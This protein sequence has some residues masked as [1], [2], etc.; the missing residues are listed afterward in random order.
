MDE[1]PLFPDSPLLELFDPLGELLG[2]GDGVYRYRFDDAVRLAGHACPTVAGA[3]VMTLR[4]LE[5]LYPG[6]RPVRGG[7]RLTFHGPPDQGANGPFSQ[8]L[9]LLT[10]A[11]AENGFAGLAGQYG[12]KGLLRFEPGAQSGPVAVTFERVD[13][14]DRV[15]LQYDASPIPPAP[16]LGEDLQ[17]VLA[18]GADPAIRTRFRSAWRD[19]TARI[20]ADAGASTVTEVAG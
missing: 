14:G 15:T 16:E 17:Q 1:P 12:R 3:F 19:R 10:G 2:A 18:G 13:S 20:V 5:R 9:T 11:A 8:I 6:E 7:M 4:A